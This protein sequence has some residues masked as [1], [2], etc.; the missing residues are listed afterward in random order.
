MYPISSST[1]QQKSIKYRGQGLT[2]GTIIPGTTPNILKTLKIPKV[3]N[4]L[5]KIQKIHSTLAVQAKKESA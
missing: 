1:P 5:A 3:L 4:T 2:Q